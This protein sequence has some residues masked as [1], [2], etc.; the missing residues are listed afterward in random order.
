MFLKPKSYVPYV[1]VVF[2]SLV[3]S[4]VL[5]ETFLWIQK[6]KSIQKNAEWNWHQKEYSKLDDVE[7]GL[8]ISHPVFGHVGNGSSVNN[9]GFSSSSDYPWGKD[10]KKFHIALLGGSVAVQIFNQLTID[11]EKSVGAKDFK[12]RCGK[13]VV[14]HNLAL[15]AGKQ[16]Q[17]LFIFQY[18]LDK[19]QMAVNLDGVNDVFFDPGPGIPTDFP[20]T[21]SLLYRMT[22]PRLHLVHELRQIRKKQIKALKILD[23]VLGKSAIVRIFLNWRIQRL[24]QMYYIKENR[25]RGSFPAIEKSHFPEGKIRFKELTENWIRYTRMQ[26]ELAKIYGVKQLFLL[27]PSAYLQG[28][29]PLSKEEEQTALHP[30]A[31]IRNERMEAMSFLNEKVGAFTKDQLPLTKLFH[32]FQSHQEQVYSDDC[33]H[34]NDRGIYLLAAAVAAEIEKNLPKKCN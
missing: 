25:L 33:C 11:L 21:T 17:Q 26:W 19:I 9:F 8:L 2:L 29:K 30:D 16:P 15:G 31:K 28:S 7:E 20:S 1:W 4:I 18:F 13:E 14:L 12:K 5:A 6:P 10:E 22:E 3:I 23:T 34:L 27:Q 24:E 32:L